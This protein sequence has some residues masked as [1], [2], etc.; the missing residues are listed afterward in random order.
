VSGGVLLRDIPAFLTA[1]A[2]CAVVGMPNLAPEAYAKRDWPAFQAMAK[3]LLG[4]CREARSP[5]V[6]KRFAEAGAARYV[7]L[8]SLETKTAQA[9][10]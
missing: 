3:R 5:E 4:H 1:G 9:G 2:D 10:R 8:S 7:D 6:R